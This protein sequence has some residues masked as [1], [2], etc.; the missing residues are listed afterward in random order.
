MGFLN[1]LLKKKDG[2]VMLGSPVTG[3]AVLLSAVSDPTFAEGILGKG[4]AVI[5]AGNQI[6]APADGTVDMI[7]PTGHAFTMTTTDGVE[8]LTHIGIDTV[9]LEGK[10]FTKHV[11][12]G[13]KVKKGDLIIT[14]DFDEI[15]KAGFDT[16]IPVIVCNTDAFKDVVLTAEGEVSQSDDILEIMKE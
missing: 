3:Q 13:A 2:K 12:D 14:A 11:A 9:K 5:P 6:V 10:F 16:V 4:A 8:V 15:K 1:G 7:F